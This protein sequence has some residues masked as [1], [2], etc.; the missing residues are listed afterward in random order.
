MMPTYNDCCDKY[1]CPSVTLSYDDATKRRDA[2]YC[3]N[4]VFSNREKVPQCR[5]NPES[6]CHTYDKLVKE[7]EITGATE[8]VLKKPA[9]AMPS[10]LRRVG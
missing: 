4:A 8:P 10:P 1:G 6:R 2:F 9:K 5:P 3:K 7:L